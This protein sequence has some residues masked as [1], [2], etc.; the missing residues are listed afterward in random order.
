MSDRIDLI[1]TFR[2]LLSFLWGVLGHVLRF[3]WLLV[4]PKTVLVAK[5]MALETQ[6]A[7]CLDAVNRKKAPKP[8]FSQAFRWFWAHVVM[9]IVPGWESLAHVMK[10]ATVVRWHR[11]G[12]RL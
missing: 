7:S 8:M 5:L 4:M 1:G 10:P 6:I 2:N 9:K 3:L 11:A 12:F